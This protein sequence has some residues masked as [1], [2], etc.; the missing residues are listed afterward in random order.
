ME[1][2]SAV[3]ARITSAEVGLRLSAARRLVVGAWHRELSPSLALRGAGRLM[4]RAVRWA[5]IGR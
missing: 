5:M 3:L 1:V 2:R 4:W